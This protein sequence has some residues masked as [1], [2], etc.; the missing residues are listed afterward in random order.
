[1]RRCRR[2]DGHRSPDAAPQRT[3][4][5]SRRT[6]TLSP[7]A[8]RGMRRTAGGQTR[9]IAGDRSGLTAPRRWPRIALKTRGGR[10]ISSGFSPPAGSVPRNM[11]TSLHPGGPLVVLR[12]VHLTLGSAAGPVNILRGISL[13]IGAGETVSVVGPSGSGKST[14][15]MVLGGLERPSA[16]RVRDRRQRS[17]RA[18]RGRARPAAPRSDRHRLPVLSPDPDDDR[19]RK[20]RDPARARR[21]ARCVR[22]RRATALAAVGLGHRLTHYPGQLSGGEQQR[23]AIARA[24]IAGPEAAARRRAD[25]QSRRRHRPA[26]HRL[27][28]RAPG[29]ARHD[30]A[31]DHPRSR[32]S[33]NA[34]SGRFSLLDGR[35]VEDRRTRAV[36]GSAPIAARALSSASPL[37]RASA[38]PPR[39]ARRHP[40][41]CGSFS[42]ASCSG[43]PRSPAIG[44]LAASVT[45]G[46]KADARDLLGGDAEARLAYRPADAAEREFLAQSGTVS[47]IATMRAMARTH[48]RRPAQP[49]RAQGGRCRLPAL[50]R[51]RVCRPRRASP[52]RS[53]GATASF[54]AAV[55]PA[56]LG[57]LGLAIG[58]SVKIGDA[59]LQLRATIEREP[60]AATGGLDLRP[61]GPDLGR[62]ARRNRADPAR[63]AGQ[64]SLPAAA[65]SRGRCGGLGRDGASRVSRGGL[66]N[67]QLR[68]GLAVAAAIDRSRRA[69]SEP[70]RPDRS[71]GRRRRDRQCGRRLHR[72]QDR[73][74]RHPQMPRRLDPAGLR[75][76]FHR[77]HGAR[78]CSASPS[79]LA[80]GALAPAL[81]VAACCAGVLP[82]SVRFGIYPAPLALAALFG[83]LTTLVFSLWPLAGIGRV[84]AGA[85]FRDTVDRARR[86]MPLAGS[87]R[88]GGPGARARRAGGRDRAGPDGRAVVRRRGD[89]RLRPLP[90]GGRGIVLDRRGGSGGRAA[91]RC[92]WRSPICTARARRP[93]RSCS[94]SASG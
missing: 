85:L 64:L 55:D 26:R 16:G 56:I 47:E 1:M 44:S 21:P 75:C 29:P 10:A 77:D 8:G 94:R 17:R 62:S 52:P 89:R 79:A 34:A 82:V 76:L 7:L 18:R 61:A 73:D 51:G 70:G 35:I 38:R 54:G 57:R 49:D 9:T 45:A 13:E 32:R 39:A 53:A 25:R 14:L 27:P 19:A 22:R 67:P 93:R 92:D 40:R 84:P 4:R 71:A 63:R 86:R 24:F 15:M 42:A 65:P 37:L 81:A 90:G 28:V 69:V 80:L 12:D 43:S 60:D 11:T 83:L 59:V 78:R 87:R 20:R 3:A 58:D 31:V 6:L 88:D 36:A 74:D 72:R 48:G 46:I 30:P 5:R 91:R 41:A 68:R 33:P 23:V 2:A 66:A 50:R